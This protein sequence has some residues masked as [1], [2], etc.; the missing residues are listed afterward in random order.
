PSASLPNSDLQQSSKYLTS[1]L[2]LGSTPVKAYAATG[3]SV[4]L[5]SLEFLRMLPSTECV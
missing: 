2:S 3:I 1:I 5:E 4:S